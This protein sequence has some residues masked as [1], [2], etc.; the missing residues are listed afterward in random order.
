[1]S[2]PRSSRRHGGGVTVDASRAA[3]VRRLR[4]RLLQSSWPRAQM[5]LIVSLT[6]GAGLL[7]SLLLLSGGMTAMGPRYALAV[8]IAYLV[9][10]GLLW[11]WLRSD[12]SDCQIDIPSPP[13]SR[14]Q[15]GESASCASGSDPPA[16]TPRASFDS[17]SSASDGLGSS[18]GDV[19][20]GDAL[21]AADEAAIPLIL[22]L[23][24]LVLLAGVFV[25]IGSVVWSAPAL[26]AELLF[27]GV[28]A[29]GL[30]RRLRRGDAQH[31]LQTALRHTFFPF[32]LTLVI[33]AGAGFAI[34]YSYPEAVTLSQALG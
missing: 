14:S 4:A 24:L 29:A 12:S 10:L 16:A 15:S 23:V 21:G 18:L 30:Y 5:L 17:T 8:A 32:L 28:L 19:G 2:R 33:V 13:S 31:W 20:L 6:A 1:M 26:F 11:L 3:T 7:S 25:V 34:Q 9:F 27:D 22:L